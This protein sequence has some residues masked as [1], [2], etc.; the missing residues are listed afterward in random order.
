MQSV[1]I[2]CI[3]AY[4]LGSIPN[5]LVFGKLIWQVDLREHGSHN[6]GAT[7]AWRTLGKGPGFLIF[8]LD[9]FKGFISV[10]LGSVLAGTPMAMV[11]AGI[12]A[13]IGH[14][15]SV[16]L[17]FKGGK[18]VAT[19]LGVIVML[20]PLPALIVFAVWLLIVKIS[21]YV[22]LGSIIAAALVP[23]LAWL[24]GYAM[25]YTVFGLLAA[26]FVIVRHKANII[27]LLNG[28]ESKIKAGH[29]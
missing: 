8:L 29:R 3:V 16:F 10:W 18:G 24:Q 20:M 2:A 25:E 21:G 5:G 12:C 11:L 6:I 23:I 19:G 4:L 9:F 27:R 14:S 1:A 13:I 26:A 7:N 22:S 15:C 28:S 17:K